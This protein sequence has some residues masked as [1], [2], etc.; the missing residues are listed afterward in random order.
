MQEIYNKHYVRVDAEE[1]II[2][3]FS[4][5]FEQP[6]EGDVCIEEQGGYQFRLLAGGEEN[7]TL[8][9]DAGVAL[10]KMEEGQVKQRTQEEI[11]ADAP[12]EVQ[13]HATVEQRLDEIDAALCELAEMIVGGV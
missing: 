11:D 13:E 4:D 1:R 3:G 2:K 10:Y 8:C 5:A 7:P 12:P 6:Q 9:D